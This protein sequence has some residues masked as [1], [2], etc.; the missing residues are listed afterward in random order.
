MGTQSIGPKIELQGEREFK[1]ALRDIDAGLKV[2]ASEMQKVTAE[3]DKNDKSMQGLTAKSDA[4]QKSIASQSDKVKLL[5]AALEK[6]AQK[7]GESDQKTMAWQTSLNNAEAELIAMNKELVTNSEAIESANKNT[8]SLGDAVT[9]LANVV[10]L[11][12]P[13]AM[14]G[15]VDKLGKVSASGAALVGVLGGIVTAMVKTAFSTAEAADVIDKASQRVG[16]TAEEYQ[17][18]AY[19]AQ[20]SGM[21]TTKLEEL[22]KKQQTAFANASSGSKDATAAYRELGIGVKYINSE[23]AFDQVIKKLADMDDTTRR[24][25]LASKIFRE[26]FADLSPLLNA[27]S[28]GIT[29]MKQEIA[30]LGGVMSNEAVKAGVEFEDSLTKLKTVGEG[31]QNSFAAALIPMLTGL[32]DVISSIPQ[33]VLQTLVVLGTVVTTIVLLVKTIRDVTST[34][35]AISGF[36]KGIDPAAMKTK[37][38]I[39]GVVAALI[40]LATIIAVIIGKTQDVQNTMRSVGESVNQ[41]N[42]SVNSVQTSSV[43]R[44]ARGTSYHP[45]GLA[46]VGEEGPELVDLPKGS[47]VYPNGA[48]SGGNTF[49]YIFKVDNIET[50]AAIERRMKNERLSLRKGYA[51]G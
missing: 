21:E 1:Q 29:S 43:P 49:N 33:P 48:A 50:Y 28:D 18:Y 40:A 3:F 34:A 7:Y 38:I 4:L 19:A 46:V 39:I 44:Y 47:R 15:M 8:L 25:A 31:L 45:G 42:N 2:N 5:Q 12:I 22:M 51:G 10:G 30:N 41:V 13:P 11:D 23:Q 37:I 16:V 27:G 24:N 20:L 6:S 17:K 36:F 9:G 35:S 14:Q 32:F 26:S